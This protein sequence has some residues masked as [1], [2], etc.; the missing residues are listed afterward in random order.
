MAGKYNARVVVNRKAVATLDL[1]HADGLLAVA[2]AV[3]EEANP[4]D[5]TPYGQGLVNAGG[6]IAYVGS[7]KV[8]GFGQD[9]RQPPKPRGLAVKGST[10]VVAIAGYGFPGR[11]QE[12][13]TVHQPARPFL[14]PAVF[15]VWPRM[16]GIFRQATAYRIARARSIGDA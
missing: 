10:E 8:G 9:G 15:R 4:P 7:K 13:G 12:M 3:V 11:F 16:Q 2:K 1:I 5:A 6:A 14:T